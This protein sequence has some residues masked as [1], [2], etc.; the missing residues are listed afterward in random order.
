MQC[1]GFRFSAPTT[2]TYTNIISVTISDPGY[3]GA[4]IYYTT[5]SKV[6]SQLIQFGGLN[7]AA[8]HRSDKQSRAPQAI[9]PSLCPV[10]RSMPSRLI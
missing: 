10:N 4:A 1:C 9:R 8:L 7:R 5:K 6:E 2:G 3:P